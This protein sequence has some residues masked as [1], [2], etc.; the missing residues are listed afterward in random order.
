MLRYSFYCAIPQ[1]GS[2]LLSSAVIE[3]VF[4]K[5]DVFLSASIT[6]AQYWKKSHPL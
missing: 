5:K 3:T 1:L 4:K 6:N 2:P